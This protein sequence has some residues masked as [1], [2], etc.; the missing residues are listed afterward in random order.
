MS[1]LIT[2]TDDGYLT[3]DAAYLLAS[4]PELL[5]A[6]VDEDDALIASLWEIWPELPTALRVTQRYLLALYGER[7]L[8]ADALRSYAGLAETREDEVAYA[9]R[10]GE[11]YVLDDGR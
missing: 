4:H 2:V 11:L 5:P 9:E 10:H 7:E 3:G 1:V 8:L 6:G